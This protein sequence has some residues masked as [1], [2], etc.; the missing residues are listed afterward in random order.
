MDLT[1]EQANNLNLKIYEFPSERAT[2][3]VLGKIKVKR[4]TIEDDTKSNNSTQESVSNE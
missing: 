2:Y 3:Q 4:K 1:Q